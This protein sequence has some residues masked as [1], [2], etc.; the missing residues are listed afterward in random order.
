MSGRGTPPTITGPPE[1]RESWRDLA[2]CLPQAQAAFIDGYNGG[3]DQFGR[4]VGN[5]A[6]IDL[7]DGTFFDG[8][9]LLDNSWVTA[10]YLWTGNG[11]TAVVQ[12]PLLTVRNGP[13]STSPAVGVAAEY[14]R[15]IVEC[16]AVGEP[17]TGS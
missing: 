4:Q 16:T 6:G 2:T 14:A 17:I 7:G 5:P 13:D 11:L 9:E 3:R 12:A 10:S 15:V 1:L 8:L